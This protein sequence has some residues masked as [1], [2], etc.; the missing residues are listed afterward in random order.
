M[1][2]GFGPS[3]TFTSAALA[4]SAPLST[5]SSSHAPVAPAHSSTSSQQSRAAAI[6][7]ALVKES[8]RSTSEFSTLERE[9][10]ARRLGPARQPV[11]QTASPARSTPI[12]ASASGAAGLDP[13]E[14]A[15]QAAVREL[16]HRM[17]MT[18]S[19][20]S[21]SGRSSMHR[22][23]SDRDHNALSQ[24]QPQ[25]TAGSYAAQLRRP[26]GDSQGYGTAFGVSVAASPLVPAGTLVSDVSGPPPQRRSVPA[27]RV[28]REFQDDD[29]AAPAM[30][31]SGDHADALYQPQDAWGT[32][33]SRT[34]LQFTPHGRGD[35]PGSGGGK[36]KAAGVSGRRMVDFLSPAQDTP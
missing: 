18:E 5:L 32:A 28:L 14:A 16:E 26:T 24:S 17:A 34:P 1:D 30:E 23:A 22:R 25:G 11:D 21:T 6:A 8:L 9:A 19:N 29:D 36:S 3:T 7:A 15:K 33:T 12:D 2:D 20:L 31:L 4:A 27:P 10:A 13:I 35:A